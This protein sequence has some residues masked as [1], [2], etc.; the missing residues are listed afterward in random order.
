MVTSVSTIAL[1]YVDFAQTLV[2]SAVV[3]LVAGSSARTR[4][5]ARAFAA[6]LFVVIQIAAYLATAI[7][8]LIVLPDLFDRLGWNGVIPLI[9]LIGIRFTLL[10]GTR[11]A[12]LNALWRRLSD[13][14]GDGFAPQSG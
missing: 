12:V 11:E 13:Q 7:I 10:C 9:A 4:E 2:L 8:G 3:G 5:D 6:A 14:L 1:L